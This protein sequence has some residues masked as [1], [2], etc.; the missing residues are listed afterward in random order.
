MKPLEI[1]LTA[2]EQL[3]TEW[4]WNLQ[5]WPW[6]SAAILTCEFARDFSPVYTATKQKAD[7]LQWF[8]SYCPDI[9]T[10]T[11]TK[12]IIM[13]HARTWN[14]LPADL[15]T[16]EYDSVLLQASSQGPPVSAV[17]HAAA[18]WWLSTVHPAPLWL[19]SEF[20]AVYKYSDLLTYLVIVRQF[21]QMWKIRAVSD[22]LTQLKTILHLSYVAG[23]NSKEASNHKSSLTLW[24]TL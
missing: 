6:L 8:S 10:H 1:S 16:P 17:V 14:S 3:I 9:D 4:A 22:R 2:T 19:F 15:R 24:S 5:K 12:C 21:S 11:S 23:S 18:D 7:N 20:G 13:D